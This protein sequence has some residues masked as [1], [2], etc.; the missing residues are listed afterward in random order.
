MPPFLIGI[1]DME[2]YNEDAINDNRI[3]LILQLNSY[4]QPVRWIKYKKSALFYAK[5]LV[6]WS[7]GKHEIILRGGKCRITGEQSKMTVNSI[8]AVNTKH[9]NQKDSNVIPTLTNKALFRRD[10][11]ICGYCGGHFHRS[12]L[13]RDHIIPKSLGGSDDWTNLVTSCISCNQKKGARTPKQANMPLMYVPYTPNYNEHLIL[14]NRN[15][16]A[17]QMDYLA[18]GIKHDSRVFKGLVEPIC[19]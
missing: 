11:N 19:A 10:H 8:I 6:L 17:D 5:G 15:I 3:P 4:G 1:L 14:Q 16:L 13:T 2:L 9:L 12:M 7:A 18:K